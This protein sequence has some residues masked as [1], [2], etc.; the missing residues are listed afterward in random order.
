MVVSGN[1]NGASDGALTKRNALWDVAFSVRWCIQHRLWNGEEVQNILERGE[2]Y[3]AYSVCSCASSQR[4][5][6]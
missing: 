2:N 4:M 5:F 3:I 6:D 1:V